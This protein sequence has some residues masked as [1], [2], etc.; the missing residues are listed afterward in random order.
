[1]RKL[2]YERTSVHYRIPTPLYEDFSKFCQNQRQSQ[3]ALIQDAIK[4]MIK[5]CKKSNAVPKLK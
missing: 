2:E 4:L 5:R 3:T 1:M